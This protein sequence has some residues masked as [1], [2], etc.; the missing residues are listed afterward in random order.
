MRYTNSELP[1]KSSGSTLQVNDNY[2]LIITL[3]MYKIVRCLLASLISALIQIE[4]NQK[5]IWE[6]KTWFT[7]SLSLVTINKKAHT[8]LNQTPYPLTLV[9][10]T[11]KVFIAPC[12]RS[13]LVLF[14]TKS[15]L[16][17]WFI[18]TGT[19]CIQIPTLHTSQC[20]LHKIWSEKSSTLLSELPD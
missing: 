11:A 9:S 8:K 12:I 18:S 15:T 17:P 4:T 2:L 1:Y 19:P 16:K 14:Q 7:F 3:S 20:N 6:T 10:S 13:K 5:L